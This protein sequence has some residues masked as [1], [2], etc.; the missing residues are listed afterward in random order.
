MI[1]L[2]I[3]EHRKL[4]FNTALI[5]GY[6]FNREP[7]SK[8]TF[9][10]G[11][12]LGFRI[13]IAK[14]FFLSPILSILYN[15][16]S[17]RTSENQ[18]N[19]DRVI[20]RY[21]EEFEELQRITRALDSSPVL[22]GVHFKNTVLDGIYS[23]LHDDDAGFLKAHQELRHAQSEL[24]KEFSDI[25]IEGV[26]VFSARQTNQLFLKAQS[27]ILRNANLRSRDQIATQQ[28]KIIAHSIPI[29][30]LFKV[31][32]TFKKYDFYSI[33]GGGI[34]I[35]KISAEPRDIFGCITM[36]LG[37]CYQHKHFQLFVGSVATVMLSKNPEILNRAMWQFKSIAGI[38][39]II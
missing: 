39:L 25:M 20:G 6:Q 19:T 26:G 14:H 12:E 2:L 8:H 27:E 9:I 32:F 21:K 11:T 10:L 36:G 34:T 30:G 38:G 15:P 28:R 35:L 37:L 22:N 13:C 18:N 23:Y 1:F 7:F 29:Q 3:S 5:G 33:M 24:R 16:L 31:G 4:S 17:P